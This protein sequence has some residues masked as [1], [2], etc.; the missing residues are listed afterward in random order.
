MTNL[1]MLRAKA[2]YSDTERSSGSHGQFHTSIQFF[3]NQ[4]FK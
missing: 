3:N 2:V 4:E 1:T